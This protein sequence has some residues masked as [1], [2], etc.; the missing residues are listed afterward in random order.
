M[1]TKQVV[2]CCQMSATCFSIRYQGSQIRLIVFDT[3]LTFS[4]RFFSIFHIQ[5][6][7]TISYMPYFEIVLHVSF[8]F[9]FSIYTLVNL[10]NPFLQAW[11]AVRA[12]LHEASLVHK[13]VKLENVVFRQRG[14]HSP[15]CAGGPPSLI[16]KLLFEKIEWSAEVGNVLSR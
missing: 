2:K 12:G 14:R 10:L 4:C 13:D 15:R 5:M 8:V 16:A 1:L 6:F 9:F 3:L 7:S 11:S